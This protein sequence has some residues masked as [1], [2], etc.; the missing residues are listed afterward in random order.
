VGVHM[1]SRLKCL[2]TMTMVGSR[3][4]EDGVAGPWAAIDRSV[5]ANPALLPWANPGL[6]SMTPNQ[7]LHAYPCRW[8]RPSCSCGDQVEPSKTLFQMVCIL[9]R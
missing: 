2:Y 8:R 4:T 1:A 9:D 6:P 5:S 7:W 3:V